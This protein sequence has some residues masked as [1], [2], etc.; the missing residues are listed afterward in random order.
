M[1]SLNLERKDLSSI[2]ADLSAKNENR[3]NA[4]QDNIFIS[5]TVDPL[6]G[7]VNQ[8]DLESVRNLS[9]TDSFLYRANPIYEKIKAVQDSVKELLL[10]FKFEKINDPLSSV[11]YK[12]YIQGGNI[13]SRAAYVPSPNPNDTLE[14]A[15]SKIGSVL[16]GKHEVEINKQST[17]KISYT[18]KPHRMPSLEYEAREQTQD[19]EEFDVGNLKIE[20]LFIKD[21]SEVIKK[22]VEVAQ[23]EV[24]RLLNR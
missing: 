6:A 13:Y 1:N 9:Q 4:V 7:I 22:V 10:V 21:E 2:Y 19:F 14:S 20:H 16:C 17:I 11:K 18:S 12:V 15:L 5:I 3:N 23:N 8:L 24:N